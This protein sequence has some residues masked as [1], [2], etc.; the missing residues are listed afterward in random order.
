M[1]YM[2]KQNLR[3]MQ[4]R[5]RVK[6]KGLPVHMVNPTPVV[7]IKESHCFRTAKTR[8]H[9]AGHQKNSEICRRKIKNKIVHD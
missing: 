4:A 8:S 1:N 5:S 9:V 2:T 7:G 6:S 3:T